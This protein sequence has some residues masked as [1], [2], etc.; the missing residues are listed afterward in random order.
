MVIYTAKYPKGIGNSLHSTLCCLSINNPVSET[1]LQEL[2]LKLQFP[3]CHRDPET[4][5]VVVTGQSL[6]FSLTSYGSISHRACVITLTASRDA[7]QL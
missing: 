4:L 3:K 6:P 2:T 1:G 7:E 5:T